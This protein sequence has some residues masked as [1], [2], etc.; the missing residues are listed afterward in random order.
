MRKPNNR[1]VNANVFTDQIVSQDLKKFNC[2]SSSNTK[3]KEEKSNQFNVQRE[4]F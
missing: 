2:I 4:F 3:K 1:F